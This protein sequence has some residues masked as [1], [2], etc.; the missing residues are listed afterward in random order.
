MRPM[1]HLIHM[2]P[3]MNAQ[4]IEFGIEMNMQLTVIHDSDGSLDHAES[5]IV[6]M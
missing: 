4:H 1:Q 2:T 6:G 5:S 3:L